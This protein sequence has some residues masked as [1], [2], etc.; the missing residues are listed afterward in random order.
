MYPRLRN[1][2]LR[3]NILNVVCCALGVCVMESWE[4]CQHWW[5]VPGGERFLVIARLWPWTSSVIHRMGQGALAVVVGRGASG[6]EAR[7]SQVS[8]RITGSRNYPARSQKDYQGKLRQETR[9]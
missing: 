2:G 7:D 9:A 4:V 6:P 5:E 8:Q 3:E 1:T